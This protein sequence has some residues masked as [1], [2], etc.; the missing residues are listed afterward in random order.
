MSTSPS[1][2]RSGGC[3]GSLRMSQHLLN[4]LPTSAQFRLRGFSA[5]SRPF[6][7]AEPPPRP[8]SLARSARW[9]RY[10]LPHATHA[11]LAP[12]LGT[13]PSLVVS[14]HPHPVSLALHPVSEALAPPLRG[15][16]QLPRASARAR[17]A[18]KHTCLLQA[19]QALEQHPHARQTPPYAT[20]CYPPALERARQH[21]PPRQGS[22]T[23][24][25]APPQ[26][27]HAEQCIRLHP[28]SSGPL[29]AQAMQQRPRDAPRQPPCAGR[30]PHLEYTRS[31]LHPAPPT[32]SPLPFAQ[33]P[34]PPA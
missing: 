31:G 13:L 3:V 10:A 24:P 9:Q 26:P 6:V 7:S 22:A 20:L 12:H 19:P 23:P 1:T 5:W 18:S 34:R 33:S 32:P 25:S 4:E 16:W 8:R 27:P 15:P 11:R 2:A 29:P 30:C 14:P 17:L 21:P 28:E